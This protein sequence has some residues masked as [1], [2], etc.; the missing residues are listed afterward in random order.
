MEQIMPRDKNQSPI[1]VLPIAQAQDIAD[2]VIA[3]GNARIIRIS[4][5]T[6]CRI[7]QYKSAKT[8]DGVL[9]PVG[10]TEY[11]SVYDGYTVEIS[12][13]ANVMG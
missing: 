7:W 5:I 1:P 8:G 4:A 9:L 2:A 11:F 12:G 3:A 10:Q 6:D 13:T